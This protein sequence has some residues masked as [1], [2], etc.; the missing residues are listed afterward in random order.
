[1]STKYQSKFTFDLESVGDTFKV[2]LVVNYEEKTFA[3]TL[4]E[5]VPTDS[6]SSA[7]GDLW[8]VRLDLIKVA[9]EFGKTELTA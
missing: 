3:T 4:S 5:P 6:I 2:D 9:I 7:L 8:L 1:M